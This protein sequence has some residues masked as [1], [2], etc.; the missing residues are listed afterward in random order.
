MNAAVEPY[1]RKYIYEG[2]W[3][4]ND[5]KLFVQRAM[6]KEIGLKRVYTSERPASSEDRRGGCDVGEI[7]IKQ[8]VFSWWI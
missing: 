5:M 3:N 6:R 8:V 7:E 4:K 2:E 1:A